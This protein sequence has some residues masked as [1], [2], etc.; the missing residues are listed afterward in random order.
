MLGITVDN[1]ALV[2]FSGVFVILLLYLYEYRGKV[3]KVE[4]HFRQLGFKKINPGNSFYLKIKEEFTDKETREEFVLKKA[5][6]REKIYLIFSNDTEVIGSSYMK[7]YWVFDND[8][9]IKLHIFKKKLLLQLEETRSEIEN[10]VKN[11]NKKIKI[12]LPED[13]VK[14]YRLPINLQEFLLSTVYQYPFNT[15]TLRARIGIYMRG[16]SITGPKIGDLQKI[17]ETM[18]TAGKLK[19]VLEENMKNDIKILVTRR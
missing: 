3:K 13:D 4:K 12:K 2:I 8:T 1:T 16:I 10:P 17:K 18:E 6:N 7:I 15:D 5:D 14:R 11:F 9:P 19:V